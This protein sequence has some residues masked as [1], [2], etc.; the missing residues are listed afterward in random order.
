MKNGI[1]LITYADSLGRNI[2][3]LH[4]FLNE[5]LSK[6]VKGV[7]ILPFYPSSAD[8]GFAPITY[9]I[10]EQSFGT[11]EQVEALGL[12]FELTVDF[13]VNHVSALSPWFRDWREKG[14]ESKWADLFIPVDRLYPAGVPAEDRE[15]IY[16]R[17]PRDP[18]IPVTFE[19]GTIRDV[20]CTFSEEQIDIDVYSETGRHWLEN[21][22]G[23][24][25]RRK[26]V[27]TVR[28][29][30]AG[31]ATKKPGTRFFFE[32]PELPELL[33]RCRSI[34]ALHDVELLPEVHEHYRYQE[35]LASWGLKVYDF[36]LP[37]LL[38]RAIYAAD[39][40]PLAAWF[41]KCPRDCITTL[42]THDG[43]GIVDVADLLT[44]EE[45]DQTVEALYEQGSN[46]NR[47]YSSASFGNL[48]L[49]QINCT[50]YSALNEN[51]NAYLAARA[52]QFFAPGIPQVYYVGLFAGRND[53]ALVEHTRQGRD[54][55]RHAYTLEEC[56]SELQRPVVKRLLA[57]MEFR[58]T[59]PAFGNVKAEDLRVEIKKRGRHLK[60]IR[61]VDGYQAELSVDFAQKRSE[62]RTSGPG[63]SKVIAV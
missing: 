47:R 24:L 52:V 57:L 48:D 6:A 16:T 60:M 42:D 3:E 45:I 62:I 32:E 50:Y 54:I 55:N 17:K 11:W 2:K 51:D 25:C 29:D 33:E 1:H 27:T 43:I 19:D 46:A 30:A 38:L 10:V 53:I 26:G 41:E 37:M 56:E 61:E 28:L 34:A 14:D 36:A 22:L 23:V 20:W 9:N 12:D 35:R 13:M 18:W 31:Y 21:E 40:Y 5:R 7:H 4:A 59:Y 15:K 58:N 63:G 49:Y 44:P 8:R 39:A